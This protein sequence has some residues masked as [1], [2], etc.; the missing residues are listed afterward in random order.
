M[1][2]KGRLVS[3]SKA[4]RRVVAGRA[5]VL[6]RYVRAGPGGFVSVWLV[7]YPDDNVLYSLTLNAPQSEEMTVEPV[8]RSIWESLQFGQR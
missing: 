8:F 4:E 2:A 7:Q 6:T 5:V 1:Q 3:C